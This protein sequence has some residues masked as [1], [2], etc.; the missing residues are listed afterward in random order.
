MRAL[1]TERQRAFVVALFD[2][3]A[4]LK[5]DG[6]FLYAARK[7]G[8]GAA[9]GSST[10]KA[11]SVIASRL[12]HDARVQAAIAEY[13]HSTLRTVAPEAIRALKQVIRDPKHRDHLKAIAAIAD[14]VDPIEQKQTLTIEDNRPPSIEATER[15][16]KRIEELARSAGLLPRPVIDVEAVEVTP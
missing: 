2:E 16:L 14:R 12:V 4:P 6:L 7:A 15:V 10:D 8:Y 3:E 9:D 13:S 5:G 11:L 1:P